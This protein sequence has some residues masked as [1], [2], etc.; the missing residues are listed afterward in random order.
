MQLGIA[1]NVAE[2]AVHRLSRGIRFISQ[3]ALFLMMFFVSAGVIARYF[4]NN[5][6]KGDLEIQELMMVLIVFLA[7]PYCQLEKR[8]VYVEVLIN[9]LKGRTK[10]ILSSFAYFI[11]FII[12]VLIVWQTGARA[13]KGFMAFHNDVTLSLWIPISPFLAVAC[14]G[15]ALT[16]I[17]WLIA[18]IYTLQIKN[19]AVNQGRAPDN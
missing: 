6:I 19:H 3:V 15:L 12:I 14:I 2:E 8:H 7:L 9:H 1:F 17:E 4:L 13:I 10:T 16:G 5:P 11:G 18:L